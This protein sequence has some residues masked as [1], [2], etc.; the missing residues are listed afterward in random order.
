MNRYDLGNTRG[1]AT[2]HGL[3]LLGFW[4]TRSHGFEHLS[5]GAEGRNAAMV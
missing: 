2:V 3:S 1:K 4:R 5:F